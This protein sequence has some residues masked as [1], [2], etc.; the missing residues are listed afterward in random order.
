MNGESLDKLSKLLNDKFT[1]KDH[2]ASFKEIEASVKEYRIKIKAALEN[3]KIKLA[4]A[5]REELKERLK[6]FSQQAEYEDYFRNLKVEEHIPTA[7]ADIKG[8][9]KNFASSKSV[10]NLAVLLAGGG[11]F[12]AAVYTNA[13]VALVKNSIEAIQWFWMNQIPEQFRMEV[14]AN[15]DY[16]QVLLLS[17]LSLGS[18]PALMWLLGYAA[19]PAM[20]VI[21]K[22]T[23]IFSERLS[24]RL[25]EMHEKWKGVSAWR[26]V[27]AFGVRVHAETFYFFTNRLVQITRQKG[28]AHASQLGLN[29]FSKIYS[30]L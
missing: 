7:S 13:D 20:S 25:L 14:L 8:R 21:A 5:A 26:K 24:S 1:A 15:P 19:A 28:F 29:P 22:T 10:R 3:K 2:E 12:S 30:R 18:I 17:T 6:F 9:L 11:A 16:N 23:S 4:F 27:L